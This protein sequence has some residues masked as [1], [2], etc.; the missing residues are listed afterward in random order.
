MPDFFKQRPHK[1]KK[2]ESNVFSRV[3]GMFEKTFQ[4]L[5]TD[6]ESDTHLAGR[7]QEMGKTADSV[8][9]QLQTIKEELKGQV[10]EELFCYVE[11]VI[12]PMIR[13][14]SRIKRSMNAEGDDIQ[15]AQAFKRYNEWIDKAKLWVH[16]TSSKQ[17]KEAISKFVITQSIR[18]FLDLIDRDLR[19]IEDYRNQAIESLRFN[20]TEY[21]AF[22]KRLDTILAPYLQTF[23]SLKE[24]PE[25]E[26]PL[27]QISIWKVNVDK[28]RDRFFNHILQVIDN[29]V[30]DAQPGTGTFEEYEHIIDI[31]EQIE[32]LEDSIPKMIASI[33]KKTDLFDTQTLLAQL[34]SAEEE[35]H[36]L[37]T[38]LRLP[39][40][41]ADRL[42]KLKTMLANAFKH[43]TH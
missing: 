18:D 31:L 27:L 19:L 2:R 6:P 43:L 7:I 25:K 36:K 37:Y 26:I 40:D 24:M 23:S 15:Q 35:V 32:Y 29:L 16:F 33:Q 20:P 10:D 3:V 38:D 42:H 17:S 13:E 8:I 39:P 11:G 4:F 12:N 5:R 34:L 9:S 30:N 21:E 1:I 28:R 22:T 14:F 41:L